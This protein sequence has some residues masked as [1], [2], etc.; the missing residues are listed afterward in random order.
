MPV[1]NIEM[2]EGRTPDQRKKLVAG[3]TRAFVEVGVPAEAVHII[4]NEHPK[5]H[6][7]IAGKLCSEQ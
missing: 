6:W 7:A 3:L 1:V 5:D 4:I 2:W